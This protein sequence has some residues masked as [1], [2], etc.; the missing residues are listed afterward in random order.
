MKF[1]NFESFESVTTPTELKTIKA[2]Y[3]EIQS[4]KC[5]VRIKVIK[6]NSLSKLLK[7]VQQR[8]EKNLKSKKRERL[9]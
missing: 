6:Y 8:V 5:P 9:G 3:E 1:Q 7:K 2:L 4:D